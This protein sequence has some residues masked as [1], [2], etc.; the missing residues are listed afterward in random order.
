MSRMRNHRATHNSALLSLTPANRNAA[1]MQPAPGMF[2][3]W[4]RMRFSPIGVGSIPWCLLRNPKES[5]MNSQHREDLI[6][7]LVGSANIFVAAL[8]G[9]LEQQL[10]AE[11]AG[12]QLTLSQL[13]VLKLLD[14]TDSRNIGDVAAFLGVSNAAASKTVDRLVRRKYLRRTEARTDRRS[15]ELSLAELGRK[16]LHR[17]EAAKNR[18]LAQV[19]RDLRPED[20]RRTA[21]YLENLTKGIVAS[22]TSSDDICLQCGIYLQRRCLMREAPNSECTYQQRTDNR[23]KTHHGTQTKTAKRG[24]SG[25]GPPG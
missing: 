14:L 17:Y 12:K 2:G 13:K 8:S 15:A 11:I 7:E 18:S 22:N 9:V 23:R 19:F 6:N 16:L 3:E 10:L 20:L 25:L 21:E 5:R 4:V 1:A 24:G